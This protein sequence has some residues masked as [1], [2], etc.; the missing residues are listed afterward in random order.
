MP[1]HR[2]WAAVASLCVVSRSH[3]QSS[4]SCSMR[5][6]DPVPLLGMQAWDCTCTLK[7]VVG[8][9][10]DREVDSSGITPIMALPRRLLR[11]T[12][13]CTE[14]RWGVREGFRNDLTPQLSE[15]SRMSQ[16]RWVRRSV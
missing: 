15:S 8:G 6:L 3:C 12:D 11:S 7:V 16:Q 5:A 2:A 9:E 13:E 1:P 4:M 14:P 10:T